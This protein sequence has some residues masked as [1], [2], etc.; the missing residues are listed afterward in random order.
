LAEKKG[1][2]KK[3]A[4]V[5]KGKTLSDRGES[6]AAWLREGK[7]VLQEGKRRQRELFNRAITRRWQPHGRESR[8]VKTRMKG[9]FLNLGGEEEQ[10][11]PSGRGKKI[12]HEQQHS[13]EKR[14]MTVVLTKKPNEPT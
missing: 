6:V 13:P 9:N 10:S 4:P 1:T 2:S 7:E 8:R 12:A 5:W 11:A 3:E 14:E